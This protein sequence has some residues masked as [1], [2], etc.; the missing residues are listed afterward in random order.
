MIF[1]SLSS[2]LERSNNLLNVIEVIINQ[3]D[4]LFLN[5]VGYENDSVHINNSKIKI[6]YFTEAGSEIR[7]FNYNDVPED[8]YYFTIDDDILYPK[9]YTDKI[10]NNMNIYNNEVVC[11]VHGSNIDK[12]LNSNFYKKNRKVFHFKDKL[13]QN[14]EVMIPGVGTSC[15]YKRN[16]KLNISNYK[17]KNMS[18]TYTGCFLAEQNVKRISIKRESNWL[19]PLDEYG[20]RIYG[21]NPYEE[22]DKMI[23]KYKSIL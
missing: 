7:F 20:V 17:T 21:N 6:N 13:D 16:M 23:N 22:I 12:N 15:F 3:C 11:C 2:I 14:T 5:L 19:I 1:M 4:V 8:S 10:I 18:D 9:D